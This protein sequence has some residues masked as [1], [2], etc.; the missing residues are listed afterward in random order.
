MNS[1]QRLAWPFVAIV[2]S[3]ACQGPSS[4]I[5]AEVLD[6]DPSNESWR[7]ATVHLDSVVDLNILKGK[8]F[9]LYGDQLLSVDALNAKG[10][11]TPSSPEAMRSDIVAREGSP[12]QLSYDLYDDG[13]GGQV[14]VTNDFESLSMLTVF[15]H[16][17]KVWDFAH[18]IGGDRSGATSKETMIGFYATVG[19]TIGISIPIL[20]SDN[21][22][23]VGM[24]DSFVILRSQILNGVPL[25]LNSAVIAHEFSHRLFFHNV[26][27]GPAF[28]NWY[29]STVAGTNTDSLAARSIVLLS[30]LDEGSADT[31][32]LTFLGRTDFISDSLQGSSGATTR[33]QRDI[34]GNFADVT[35]YEDLKWD[36]INDPETGDDLCGGSSEDFSLSTWNFYCLGTVWARS[37]WDASGRDIEVMRQEIEPA[38]IRSMRRLGDEH[39]ASYWGFDFDIIMQLMAEEVPESRRPQ[40]CAAFRD[41][42][43]ILTDTGV[44]AC[45]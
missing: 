3:L 4:P 15:N 6:F 28:N 24:S 29:Q 32:A 43:Q 20:T 19:A 17:E 9:S 45:W 34:E 41:K 26:Y 36:T 18:N 11:S 8:N 2:A 14:A 33:I 10:S 21:A 31:H 7:L 35:T 23:F 5:K 13:Q 37:L 30:A 44:P 40:L 38:L 16:F 42:F 12:V 25:A 22:A 1:P 39:L 27:A